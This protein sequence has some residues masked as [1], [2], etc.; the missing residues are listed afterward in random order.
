[1]IGKLLESFKRFAVFYRLFVDMTNNYIGLH[2]CSSMQSDAV[3]KAAGSVQDSEMFTLSVRRQECLMKVIFY[4]LT[5]S[6]VG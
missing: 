5:C 4:E 1:M 6:V 3:V 2:R